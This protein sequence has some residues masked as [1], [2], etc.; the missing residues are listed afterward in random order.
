MKDILRPIFSLRVTVSGRLD[1][2]CISSIS[3]VISVN[4]Y[5]RRLKIVPCR[6]ST[7]IG[8][9]ESVM[10]YRPVFC[11]LMK[12]SYDLSILTLESSATTVGF[13]TFESTAFDQL[14]YHFVVP[15]QHRRMNIHRFFTEQL[16]FMETSYIVLRR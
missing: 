7:K 12:H 9:P 1:V 4:R 16:S 11:L 14:S 5:M 15:F 13:F 8:V 6:P 10:V 2:F 3:A